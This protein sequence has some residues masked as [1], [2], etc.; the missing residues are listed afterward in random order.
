MAGH[1]MAV[2][3]GMMLANA[4]SYMDMLKLH[5]WDEHHVLSMCDINYIIYIYVRYRCTRGE[6]R[7][8]ILW[9][10]RNNT[11]RRMHHANTTA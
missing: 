9:L 11:Q 1:S 10:A 5:R 7:P 4:A 3:F 8:T 6:I 2:G